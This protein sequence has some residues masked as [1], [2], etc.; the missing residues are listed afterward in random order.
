MQIARLAPAGPA[1]DARRRWMVIASLLLHAAL[2]AALFGMAARRPP[3]EATGPSYELVFDNGPSRPA[4]PSGSSMP[5]AQAADIP[6]PDDALPGAPAPSPTSP[7]DPDGVA[8]AQPESVSPAPAPL[9]RPD[10]GADPEVATAP[11]PPPAVAA[12]ASPSQA[13]APQAATAGPPT[14]AFAPP[15]APAETTAPAPVEVLPE[16]SPPRTPPAVRLD[17]PAE[18]EETQPQ[19]PIMPRPPR[20]LPP[21]PPR[22][23]PAP[24]LLPGTLSNPMDLSFAPSA[25][26]PAPAARGSAAPRYVDLSPGPPRQGPNRNDPYAEIRAANAS[27]DWNRGLLAYWLRHRYYPRQAA[28]NGEEGQVVIELTVARSGHVDEVRVVSR[29]GSQW[30]DMAALGTFRNANLPPFTDEMREDRLTFPI[31]IHYYLI[32][33]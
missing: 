7:P 24:R 8:S 17:V 26:R 9:A 19:A 14:L 13:A 28:E 32:R 18:P 30:L 16:P 10:A 6:L 29:S 27:E 4:D 31:P 21:A 25:P 12:P 11:P 33:H 15:V 1:Q 20:P 22:P 2:F 5:P 3:P 23:R